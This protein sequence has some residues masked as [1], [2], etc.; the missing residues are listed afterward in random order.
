MS[1]SNIVLFVCTGN[2]YRSRYAELYFNERVP[3]EAGWRAESRGFTLNE[4]N[5][6]PISPLVPTRMATAGMIAPNEQRMPLVLSEDDLRRARYIVALD[7]DEHPPYV[8]RLFPNWRDQFHYW[9]I[10]DTPMMASQDALAGIERA[11]D[12]LIDELTTVQARGER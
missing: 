6:G 8:E 10:G 4:R 5:I 1:D 12:S 2:Y 9:R 3:P 7:A 11:V